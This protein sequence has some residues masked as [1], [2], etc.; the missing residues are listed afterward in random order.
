[1]VGQ[2]ATG[3]SYRASSSIGPGSRAADFLISWH[4][5]SRRGI[6]SLMANDLVTKKTRQELREHFVGFSLREIAD[7]CEFKCEVQ[8][9]PRKWCSGRSGECGIV[10]LGSP[11]VVAPAGSRVQEA[12]ESA[13]HIE[14]AHIWHFDHG[15][16]GQ[17]TARS[18]AAASES[19][20]RSAHVTIPSL[21][22][23]FI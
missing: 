3:P 23:I 11:V 9:S 10:F 6:F 1:M 15:E 5:S 13:P 12:G 2:F 14:S 20:N 22:S 16:V 7:E 18:T 19:Q 4:R 17:H 21:I 8:R